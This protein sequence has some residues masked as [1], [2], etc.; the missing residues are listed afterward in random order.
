MNATQIIST[1]T[2]TETL[3]NIERAVFIGGLGNNRIDASAAVIS[4][5]LL[6]GAGNDTLL[7]GSQPDVLIG[8]SRANPS[9]GTDSLTG[10][11]GPD[12]FDND[13]ADTRVADDF[14]TVL[15]NVLASI[16]SWI[17]AL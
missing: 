5:T 4:V 7:G 14:D 3:T 9:D 6:G 15:A 2:G 10:N 17:D 12:T 1:A 13:P 11:A 16:P 8:G